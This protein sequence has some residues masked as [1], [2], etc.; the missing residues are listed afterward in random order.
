MQ[1]LI[2]DGVRLCGKCDQLGRHDFCGQCGARFIG[3]DRVW[4][5]CDHCKIEASVPF[6][7][8]CGRELD[9][10]ELR[11]WETGEVD[12]D[13]EERQVGAKLARM[14]AGNQELD[15]ALFEDDLDGLRVKGLA[16]SLNTGFGHHA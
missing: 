4:R 12:L 11:R 14:L 5:E 3:P 7:P 6:C 10:D 1:G 16:G 2:D 9:C 8:T 15:R 13:A